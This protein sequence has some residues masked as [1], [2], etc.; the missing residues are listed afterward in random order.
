MSHLNVEIKAHCPNPDRIRQI[1]VSQ[2]AE[3]KGID[4]QIDTYFCVANGRLKLREGT[5]EYKLIHYERPNQ[6]V[7]KPSTVTLYQPEPDSTLKALLARALG[8]LVVVDKHREIYFIDNVKFHIDNVRQLG[9]FV[10]I[11]AIDTTGQLDQG[12]LLQQC[13]TYMTLLGIHNDD[14]ID[15]SYSDMLLRDT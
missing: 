8:V 10:E 15:C 7:P 5:I 13:R 6:A 1:L 12:T 14:L 3:F 11:E 9:S 4:H 2:D